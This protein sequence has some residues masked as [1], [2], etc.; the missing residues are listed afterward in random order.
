M[1]TGCNVYAVR[2]ADIRYTSV[3]QTSKWYGLSYCS[4]RNISGPVADNAYPFGKGGGN[5]LQSYELEVANVSSN[6]LPPGRIG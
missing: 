6:L 2:R 4:A 1:L 3:S 5:R